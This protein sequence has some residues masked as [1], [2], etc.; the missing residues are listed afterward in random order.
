MAESFNWIENIQ[1]SFLDLWNQIVAVVPSILGA[2]II[3]IIGWLIASVVSKIIQRFLQGAKVDQLTEQY[4]VRDIFHRV[5]IRLNVSNLISWLIKW[6]LIIVFLTAAANTL[7]WP[8]V[9]EFIRSIALYIPNVIVA[10]IILVIGL[11]AARFIEKLIRAGLDTTNIAAKHA[12]LLGNTSRIAIIG[13]A[14]LAALTQLG[15]APQLI[16]ILFAGLVATLALAFGL[17]GQRKA[18]EI[19]DQITWPPKKQ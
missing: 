1:R 15:I 19:L 14:M 3:F 16:Q 17:G 13:F 12:K 11:V 9:T 5:N 2:A 6:F 8:Q 4:V 10:V 18:A 7:G